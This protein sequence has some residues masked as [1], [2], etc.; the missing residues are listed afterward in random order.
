M[1]KAVGGL[2]AFGRRRCGE[3]VLSIWNSCVDNQMLDDIVE[4]T[5]DEE[6]SLVIDFVIDRHELR[7]FIGVTI[8]IRV[9]R[10]RGEPVREMVSKLEGRKFISQ[11]MKRTRFEY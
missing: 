7:T 8:L 3:T 10:G 9:Y 11:F 4:C 1:M 6:R 5:H 2:S